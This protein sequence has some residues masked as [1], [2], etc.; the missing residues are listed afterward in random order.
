MHCRDTF[1]LR[2]ENTSSITY[3]HTTYQQRTLRAS[4]CAS[5]SEHSPRFC[6]RGVYIASFSRIFS[7]HFRAIFEHGIALGT[8]DISTD[9]RTTGMSNKPNAATRQMKRMSRKISNERQVTPG[10]IKPM[11]HQVQ[12][13]PCHMTTAAYRHKND[14]FLRSQQ[15]A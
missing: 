13:T 5:G 3:T 10:R 1:S 9:H 4:I 8:R 15:Q 2:P 7:S 12:R 11:S 14:D 6:A